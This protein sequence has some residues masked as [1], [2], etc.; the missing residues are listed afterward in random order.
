MR[1]ILVIAWTLVCV[2]S[3]I[4]AEFKVSGPFPAGQG[5]YYNVSIQG[6]I[7]PND[8]IRFEKATDKIERAVVFLGSPG[9][10]VRAG[11]AIGDIIRKKKYGT[12]V[13]RNRICLSICAV[14]WLG[15]DKKYISKTGQLGFHAA[16]Y[17]DDEGKNMP[18]AMANAM[19][20]AYLGKLGYSYDLAALV[21]SAPPD[22]MLWISANELRKM[23]VPFFVVEELPK[24]G[25]N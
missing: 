1:L 16:Y 4:A 3:A 15:G 2:V 11:I 12:V 20:G 7:S 14:I 5:P 23:E 8:A 19:I 22:G 6:P 21:T 18:S 9:G 13:N 10:S 24:G 17:M 25:A